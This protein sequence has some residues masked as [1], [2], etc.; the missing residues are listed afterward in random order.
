MFLPLVVGRQ[1]DACRSWRAH[2]QRGDRLG[3]AVLV[4][5]IVGVQH[6]GDAVDLG[7]GL[8]GFGRTLA[9]D[10]DM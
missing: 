5:G 4:G 6:L 8:G 7:G 1:H 3:Q 9:R 10:Q 2:D